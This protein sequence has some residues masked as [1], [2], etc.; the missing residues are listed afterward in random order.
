MTLLKPG[1]KVLIAERALSVAEAISTALRREGFAIAGIVNSGEKAIEYTSLVMPD[2]VLIDSSL[3]GAMD[4][5]TAGWKI[6]TELNCPVIY[7]TTFTEDWAVQQVQSD[8]LC[9]C[10]IKPFSMADLKVAIANTLSQPRLQTPE[11]W[12]MPLEV[13]DNHPLLGLLSIASTIQPMPRIFFQDD[14]LKIYVSTRDAAQLLKH[15]C[16]NQSLLH[17]YQIF[18]WAWQIGQYQPY[19]NDS[20][21]S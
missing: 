13:L 2:V 5:I 10:L 7:M 15:T 14:E 9:E 12:A 6:H 21:S 18:Y 17:P 3:S 19:L 4:S 20:Q 8:L 1:I 16:Q 11:A